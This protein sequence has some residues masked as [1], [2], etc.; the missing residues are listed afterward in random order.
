MKFAGARGI[1]RSRVPLIAMLALAASIGLAGCEG[2]DGKDGAAGAPGTPGTAG[3]VGPTGP[4]GPTGPTGPVAGIEKP[5]ESC[6]VCHGD[7]S[8]AAVDVEH[9]L[10]DQGAFA[11]FA[12]ARDVD[13]LVV[14]FSATVDGAPATN[15]TFYALY[16]WDGAT[17][18]ELTSEITS[19]LFTN[20][21]DGT[22]RVRIV[23]G[24]TRFG[25]VN[26]RYLVILRSGANQLEIAAVGDYPSAIPL[27]GLA[28]NKACIDCH[29]ASGQTGRFAPTN[30]GGHYSAP[31]SADAC[32]VCHRPT[33]SYG[34]LPYVVHGIHAAHDFPDGKFVTGRGTVYETTYP[35]YM[36]NCSVCH[37]ADSILPATGKSALE[38][39]NAM[40]VTGAGCF[41][42][43][44]S[45]K[46][47]DFTVSGTTFHEGYTASTDCATCHKAGGIAPATVAEFHNGLT[48]ERGGLI[49][50]GVDTSVT[51]GAKFDWRITG[52]VDDK[53]NLKISWTAKYNGTDVNPCNATLAAGAPVFHAGS[54]A[55]GTAGNLSM[56]RSYFQGD[57]PVLGKSPSAPG[58]ALAVNVTTAN[59]ACVGNVATTTIAVD[60]DVAGR[61]IVALQGK[62]Y[63]LDAD[64]K[65]RRVRAKTPT[66]EF[67]VGTGAEPTAKRRAI[68]D[69]GACLK[70]HVGSLYQH[71]GNRVDNVDMCVICHN[72]ASS[73]QNVRTEMGVDKSEAYDGKSGMTYEFKTM[74]HA[75]HTSGV[76]GQKPVVIYRSNGIYA[77]APS[78]SLLPNWKA[79][80]PCKTSATATTNNGNIVFGSNPET[81]RTHNFHAP[82]Y[83]RAFNDCA[84]CHTSTFSPMVDQTK[85]VATTLDAGAAPWNNQLDDTLQGANTAA[86]TSCHQD[87]PSVGHANQNGWVPTKFPNGRQTII[88]AAK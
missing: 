24:Y 28:S 36:T 66:R 54:T 20:V 5:L 22:Y 79:G 69:T 80:A 27:A 48:T 23:G 26:N 30:R 2:D 12:V 72:S 74:L 38:A 82:T 87:G 59:T 17:R 18:T 8:L 68:A 56:L 35:T 32:V 16:K 6:A 77:W 60:T 53:T 75:I 4:A 83:P 63:V 1:T 73:E 29:G 76:T 9:Q 67:V 81:C 84:A 45:M 71:G 88:D 62:P 58:Q 50:N 34:D 51:E 64:N 11:N 7:N 13:D 70:C 21:G 86:C 14:S 41:S 43:H 55:A 61:G 25:A 44:G 65:P 33:A 39:A 42:C 37:K 78:E 3:P 19:G 49:W 47:W 40:P 15:A 31:M 46:S 52:I 85:G 57:D 10:A